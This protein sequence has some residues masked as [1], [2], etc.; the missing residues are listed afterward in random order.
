MALFLALALRVQSSTE[1]AMEAATLSS[2][3]GVAVDP[4]GTVYV[5]DY[6]HNTIRRVTPEGEIVTI[7]GKEGEKGHEDG[8][9]E[10]ARFN[11]PAGI[12][13]DKAGTLFV[14]DEGSSTIRKV[15]SSGTVTTVAGRAGFAGSADGDPI[16]ARFNHPFGIAVGADDTLYV[17]DAAS[18]TIRKIT[19]SGRVSTLAGKAG[20][21]GSSDGTGAA[22][23]FGAPNGLA[24]DHLGNLF[25]ADSANGTIRKVTPGGVVTTV[26]G[27][28]DLKGAADGLGS[29]ARFSSGVRGL[30]IGNDG[31]LYVGDSWNHAIRRI[32]P[33]GLVSTLAGNLGMHGWA[34]GT[35]SAAHFDDPRGTAA[36]S[37][38]NLY[39]ADTG[40]NLLRK[41]TPQGIVT[42]FAGSPPTR[43]SLL[44]QLKQGIEEILKK[45]HT[46]G[47]GVAIVRRDG[48]EWIA[49]IGLADVASLR[50]ATAGT[51]FRIGSVS[52]GFVSL[53]VLKLQQEGKLDLQDTLKSRAPDL[54]FHNPWEATDPVRIVNLL[55][56]TAG[57]DDLSM[58][59]YA[60]DFPDEGSLK[61]GLAY[62]RRSL[63]SRWKPGTLYSYANPGPPAAA[64]VVERISGQRFEDYVEQNWFK[65]LR[66]G[67]ASYFYT[68][69]VRDRLAT[70]YHADGKTPF[71]YW[72]IILRPAGSINASATDMANYVQFYLNRGSFDGVQL[73]PASAIDRMEL[74]TTTY[75]AREGMTTGYGLSN[76][77][78][79]ADGWL[80]HGHDGGV[81]GG[82]TDFAYLPKEG[83][84]YVVMINSSNG[85]TLWEIGKLLRE[86]ITREQ[87]RTEAG[88]PGSPGLA[89]EYAGWY[90]LINPRQEWT[91]PFLKLILL[92][93]RATEQGM[94]FLQF[95]LFQ[96]NR[97][98][99]IT[100]RIY[101]MRNG[102]FASLALIADHSDGT[103]I[104]ASMGSYRR[105]PAWRAFLEMAVVAAGALL[106]LSTL[107]F[108]LVWVP[109]RLFGDLK[110]V[111]FLGVRALPA[112]AA[113]SFCAGT[114][115]MLYSFGSVID[116]LGHLTPASGGIFIFMLAF[117]LLSVLGLFQSLR[118]RNAGIRRLVW[119]HAFAA[120]LIFTI[121]ALYLTCGGFIGW[122]PWA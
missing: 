93:V 43:E 24:L 56:H 79:D 65:P 108:S 86:Y 119:W 122:R 44:A 73:L 120:S 9:A 18:H 16:H 49:G 30:S 64:Y 85:S 75:A 27:S 112:L 50:P 10:K 92:K 111:G 4:S 76:Y 7:A 41:V 1:A 80:Y 88:K 95:G 98:I 72:H 96:R 97:W 69:A 63:T 33:N 15:T 46:P 102:T 40:N 37:S 59:A 82:L 14:A 84:G 52:K 28:A 104:D 26:A 54:E 121:A 66:M 2:P 110:G 32:A 87:V 17:S 91:R 21:E 22:A 48:P 106:L 81:E 113:L 67:T 103:L 6:G 60:A 78:M 42:T 109:R 34:D 45:Q 62:S 13:V 118:H 83:V 74:P 68:P 53:S 57:W 20:S 19:A 3:S 23:R 31:M 29:L 115:C 55:E 51:L 107:I 70:L 58:R 35:G 61:E 99:P 105:I 94:S 90:E 117:A 11:G 38:G 101:R 100:S 12:A 114:G 39:V 71:P 36:D 77:S 5:A 25:V 8:Q 47:A 89:K 116:R